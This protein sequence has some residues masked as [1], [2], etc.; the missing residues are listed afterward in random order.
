MAFPPP[1][2]W[3]SFSLLRQNQLLGGSIYFDYFEGLAGCGWKVVVTGLLGSRLI[4]IGMWVLNPLAIYSGLP[5]LVEW[6]HPQLVWV[7]PLQLTQSGDILIDTPGVCYHGDF[8][9]NQGDK[10][11]LTI[12]HTTEHLCIPLCSFK[13]IP[14]FSC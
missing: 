9:P 10:W 11:R 2:Y 4:D 14:K 6:C 13:S 8:K 1:P 7:F 5:M 3:L 12:T